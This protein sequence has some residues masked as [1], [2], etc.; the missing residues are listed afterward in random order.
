MT[1]DAFPTDPG[2]YRVEHE[3][4]PDGRLLSVDVIH[5]NTSRRLATYEDDEDAD[6]RG[7]TRILAS[8]REMERTDPFA[9]HLPSDRAII[10]AAL[11]DCGITT[12]EQEG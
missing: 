3:R 5:K 4:A 7:L 2:A 8:A 10:E 11:D 1:A 6:E 9:D 12:T